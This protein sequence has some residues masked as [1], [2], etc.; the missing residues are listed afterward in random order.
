MNGD[1]QTPTHLIQI[2]AAILPFITPTLIALFETL[3][4]V[5]IFKLQQL[6]TGPAQEPRE[7]VYLDMREE[8]EGWLDEEE[9]WERLI[10]SGD[11]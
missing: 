6:L 9:I 8:I 2:I 7:P 5:L 11:Q 10:T 1:D 3:N 4:K